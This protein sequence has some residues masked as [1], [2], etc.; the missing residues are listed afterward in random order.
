M[1]LIES[2]L[3]DS[4]GIVTLTINRPEVLNAI[5]VPLARALEAAVLP[6]AD[7]ARVRCVVIRGAGR[8]FVAGG[9]LSGFAADFDAAADVADELLDALHPVAETLRSIDAPVIAG[10][11]G[12]VAGAGLSLMCSCD[13]A[14]AAQGTRFLMAYDRVGAAPDFGGTYFLPRVLGMRRAAQ[15]LFLSETLDAEAALAAGMVNRVVPGDQLD[16][17]VDETARKIAAG[18]TRAFGQY[19]RLSDRAFERDLHH[20]LEA[21]RAAFKEATR[22]QDFREGIGAFLAKRVPKFQGR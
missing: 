5:D 22:T 15:F 9:D 3:D 13:L 16:A 7:D 18:P 14:I 2:E 20:Q 11:H 17:A 10:V 19:K 12:A 21:E 4:T 6:L 8:A 1:S